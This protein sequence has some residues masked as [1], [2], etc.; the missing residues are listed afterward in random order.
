MYKR[1]LTGL[2]AV[3]LLLTAPLPA[4]GLQNNE[5]YALD[6]LKGCLAN[7]FCT[8]DIRFTRTTAG[9]ALAFPDGPKMTKCHYV[10]EDGD[11]LTLYVYAIHA[12][13]QAVKDCIQ[14]Y[15]LVRDDQSVY[16][17]T[18]LPYTYYTDGHGAIFLYCGT[19]E[20]KDELLRQWAKCTPVGGYFA[21]DSWEAQ[22]AV[23]VPDANK[24]QANATVVTEADVREGA[25]RLYPALGQV[26][27]GARVT[28]LGQSGDWAQIKSN[29][30]W[31]CVP[32]E[33]LK[34]DESAQPGVE[35]IPAADCG[36]LGCGEMRS[37][38]HVRTGPGTEHASL[39][40]IKKGTVVALEERYGGW[41]RIDWF[42]TYGPAWVSAKYVKVEE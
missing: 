12:D 6:T 41:Y 35:I 23:F 42:Q 21:G 40:R 33:C 39:G 3:L 24:A 14:G 27:A 10:F 8:Y 15:A 11:K 2:L 18:E 36:E 22:R 16:A 37:T 34:L 9:N 31:S 20:K 7:A 28:Y 29:N 4:L 32:I 26:E 19:E 13:M 25:N 30:R 17:A 1:M 38:V 5:P